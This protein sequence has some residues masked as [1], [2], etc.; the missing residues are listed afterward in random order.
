MYI[1]DSAFRKLI[2]LAEIWDMNVLSIVPYKIFPA[3]FGG[4]KTIASFNEY[5]SKYHHLICVTVKDND[6]SA[7]PYEI[8]NLLSNHP[9]RYINFFYFRTIRKIIKRNKIYCSNSGF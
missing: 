2:I 8:L 4:Q 9:T 1:Q 5:F 3:R 7:A 6:P